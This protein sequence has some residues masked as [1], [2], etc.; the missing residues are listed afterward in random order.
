MIRMN[1]LTL[2][3]AVHGRHNSCERI[4]TDEAT[5]G[6]LAVMAIAV[7]SLRLLRGHFWLI[8]DIAYFCIIMNGSTQTHGARNKV[9]NNVI[10]SRFYV[11]TTPL[12]FA[13]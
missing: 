5:S 4:L 2:L 3:R 13:S 1:K 6:S 8:R 10:P 11:V 7:K 9:R 12:R